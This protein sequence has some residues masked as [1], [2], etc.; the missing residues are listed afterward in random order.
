MEYENLLIEKSDGV[1]TLTINSPRTLNALNSQVLTELECALYELNLDESVKV[2]ILTG[3]GEKA[4]VAGADIKEMSEMN[5]FEAHQFGLKGQRVMMLIEK[6]TK[7]VIAAVN[8]YAL[9]GGLELALAC[10]F[11]YAS[12]K[13][14]V[15]FPEVTLG[16]MPGFGGTQNL[17]RLIGPNK[18]NEMIF[19]GKMLDA[20]KAMEWGIVNEVF[21][22]G[23]LLAKA[24]ET[25]GTIAGVGTVGVAYAKDAI[26]NGLNMGKEDGFRYEASLFGVLFATQDQK[27]GMGAFVEKRKAAFK[28]K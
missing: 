7:P 17:A 23:E 14:K 26:A 21:P 13:A 15:G 8:G 1:V 28:G 11:I 19:T 12:E 4:F 5:S 18:A 20:A 10:D 2:V 3:A 9:G 27:E 6:M 25:A 22:A 16:I 24:R